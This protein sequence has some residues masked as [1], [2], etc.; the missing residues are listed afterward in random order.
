MTHRLS[1]PSA[2]GIF[3]DQGS[4]PCLLPWQV[5][6]LPLSHQGSPG[7]CFDVGKHF[8]VLLQSPHVEISGLVSQ[9]LGFLVVLKSLLEGQTMPIFPKIPSTDGRL[10]LQVQTKSSFR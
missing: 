2:R 1:C 3:L 5:D 7:L 9:P 4:N 10:R 8:A 6:S